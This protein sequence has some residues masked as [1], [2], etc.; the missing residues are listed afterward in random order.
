MNDPYSA[1]QQYMD[2]EDVRVNG[3]RIADI[4]QVVLRAADHKSAIEC[5][6]CGAEVDTREAKGL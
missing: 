6:E 5:P 4:V 1:V 2:S 3:W